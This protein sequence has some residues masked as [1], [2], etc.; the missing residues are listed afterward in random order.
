MSGQLSQ[1]ALSSNGTSLAL[2]EF[3]DRMDSK[4]VHLPPS[5]VHRMSVEN[6]VPD[7]VYRDE[8]TQ[9]HDLALTTEG[10]PYLAG[11]S[12]IGVVRDNLYSR[13]AQGDDQQRFQELDRDSSGLSGRGAPGI[14][15]D[16]GGSGCVVATEYGM[17]LKL[18]KE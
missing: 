15:G 1:V 8:E 16:R 12:M 3:G 11:H 9:D 2:F 5:E 17:I 6:G 4:M 7:R 14:P 18:Q 13:E 10:T